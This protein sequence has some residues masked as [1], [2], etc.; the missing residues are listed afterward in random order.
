MFGITSSAF[1]TSSMSSHK[2]AVSINIYCKKVKSGYIKVYEP[3]IQTGY[4]LKYV[5]KI[6]LDEVA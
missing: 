2:V 5:S 4:I 6:V 3:L 1:S